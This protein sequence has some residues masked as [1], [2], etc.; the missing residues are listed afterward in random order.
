[1]RAY[2]FTDASL[3]RYAGQFVWLSIDI[4]N[5]AN[6]KF[7]SKYQIN[8]VPT[9]LIIDPK[10]E[11]V[12]THYYGGLT[13]VSLKRLLDDNLKSKPDEALVR[14]DRFSA[15]GKHAEAAKAYE[16]ALKNL[17][18]KSAKYG[19]AAE[20]YTIELQSTK[21]NELCVS[22]GLELAKKL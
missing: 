8:G 14:A 20:S 3:A 12:S 1:M 6:A 2:V 5:A 19:R 7:L 18:T 16:E 9:F 15:E 22:Q 4:D 17:S 21:Q 13:L 11:A 10:K